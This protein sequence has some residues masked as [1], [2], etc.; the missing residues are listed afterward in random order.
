MVTRWTWNGTQTGPFGDLQPTG[1]SDEPRPASPS[2]EVAEGKIVE[3]WVYYNALPFWQQL[4]FTLTP[5]AE[6]APE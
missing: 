2:R 1:N 6:E 5:A 4:G 3:E